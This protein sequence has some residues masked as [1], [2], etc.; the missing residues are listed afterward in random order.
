MPSSFV[1]LRSIGSF[2]V[3]GTPHRV[4]GLPVE[5]RAMVLG[6]APR[7]VDPN[8]DYVAGQMYVQRFC[9]ALP[10]SPV[11]VLFWHGGGMTGSHWESTPDGRR[12]WLWRFLAEGYDV[13]V[14]DA[15]E[16]GRSSWARYPEIYAGPPCFRTK[17]EA[18]QMF[19]I[20]SPDGYAS[21]PV[22]RQAYPGQQFPV[23]SFDEFAKQWVPRWT[24]HE[25]MALHAYSELI[26]RTGPCVVVAH[27]Q[28]AGYAV[29]VAQ[30]HPDLVR[31][32]VA[33]E[34]GGMP[35]PRDARLP[36]HLFVWGDHFQYPHAVWDGYRAMADAYVARGRLCPGNRLE[37]LTL[38]AAGFAGN[39]HFPM[40]DRNSDA[41]A[42]LVLEWLRDLA[43]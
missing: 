25:G 42:D 16:R 31:A 12:G 27:S 35:E 3:G 6:G 40:L 39:S 38:P 15:V 1:T 20:G 18:W 43:L 41:I 36:P 34:P 24:G 8:G 19:R 7:R 22:Q 37:T 5:S 29:A 26:V 14:S 30:R 4:E 28:G 11:P 21:D 2:F 32:V 17:E 9:L 10:R 13:L 33:I 23:E